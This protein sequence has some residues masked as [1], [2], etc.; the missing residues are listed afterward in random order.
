[1]IALEAR[2]SRRAE[3]FALG[4]LRL[5]AASVILAMAALLGYLAY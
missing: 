2:R 5:A 1:V 4:V 3:Q